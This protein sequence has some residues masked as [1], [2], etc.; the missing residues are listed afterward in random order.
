MDCCLAQSVNK[1]SLQ[2]N[3][4]DVLAQCKAHS[5]SA[6]HVAPSVWQTCISKAKLLIG[7]HQSKAKCAATVRQKSLL[8]P[9]IEMLV[10][11]TVCS[12]IV[13]SAGMSISVISCSA[14]QQYICSF[15]LQLL[16]LCVTNLLLEL[17]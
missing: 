10:A 15:V 9:S 14:S 3:S 16:Q 4:T 5:M 11:K 2:G 13:S 12:H 1:S 7:S 17:V 6:K 8:K